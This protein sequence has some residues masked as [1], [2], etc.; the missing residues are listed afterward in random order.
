MSDLSHAVMAGFRLSVLI[1]GSAAI[2]TI[3][4][5]TICRWL[6]WAPVNITVNV[7][8]YR[9]GVAPDDVSRSLARSRDP[10]EIN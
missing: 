7:N 4:V 6:K 10:S 8:D 2:F 5:V 1:G 9:H 3:A